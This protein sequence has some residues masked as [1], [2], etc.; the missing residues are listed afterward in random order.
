MWQESDQR[1]PA[2]QAV[3]GERS[4]ESETLRERNPRYRH[5]T[6]AACESRCSREVL[7]LS[8]RTDQ[9]TDPGTAG[10]NLEEPVPYNGLTGDSASEAHGLGP[11]STMTTG[12]TLF[13]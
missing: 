11:L 10:T 4:V 7:I 1:T 6:D 9:W 13:V 8:P 12:A 5:T 3:H 2:P